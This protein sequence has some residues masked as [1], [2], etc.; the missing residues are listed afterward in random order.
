MPSHSSA[1]RNRLA[2]AR[3]GAFAFRLS[4]GLGVEPPQ[5]MAGVRKAASRGLLHCLVVILMDRA[6]LDVDR[7]SIEGHPDRR[8]LSCRRRRFCP[9]RSCACR[10]RKQRSPPVSLWLPPAERIGPY[11]QA[12]ASG[13]GPSPITPSVADDRPCLEP[14]SCDVCFSIL[15]P[16][17]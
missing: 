15:S 16:R 12:Q 10:P 17:S 8:S 5:R 4:F 6:E 9:A 7:L 13:P 2:A 14:R 3:G 1:V 11:G